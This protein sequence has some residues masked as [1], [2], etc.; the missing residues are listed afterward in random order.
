MKR[1]SINT[2]WKPIKDYIVL[3]KVRKFYMVYN[4]DAYIISY[5]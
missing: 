3:V 1:M 4:Q 5:K 2:I